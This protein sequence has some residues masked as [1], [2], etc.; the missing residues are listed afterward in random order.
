MPH[1]F[2]KLAKVFYSL[3]AP[4]RL[5]L[6]VLLSR[7][8]STAPQVAHE[9]NTSYTNALKQL[10]IL[11]AAGWLSR[12]RVHNSYFYKLDR[13]WVVPVIAEYGLSLNTDFE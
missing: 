11:E 12:T 7:Q 1:D 8:S 13:S 6:L 5:R 3:S 2:D 10:C 4:S 9:L